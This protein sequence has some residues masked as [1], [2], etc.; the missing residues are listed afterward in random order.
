MVFLLASV[1]N[2]I[3][4]GPV[5]K[6]YMVLA[7]EFK[8][9]DAIITF[10]WDTLL[11]RALFTS[12]IWSPRNGYYIKPEAIYDDQWHDPNTI[13]EVING[14]LYLKVHG[15]TNWLAPY[16]S[17]NLTTGEKHSMSNYA[18]DKLFLFFKATKPYVTYEDR[19][20]GSYEP[21][22]YCYYPPNLPI[23]RDN[24]ENGH[25][26]IRIVSACDLPE[27]G[28]TVVGGKEVYSIPMIV[29]PVRNKQY[30][31]YGIIFISLW[32]KSREVLS[33]CKQLF[34]I[35]YSFPKT[36]IETK[37]VFSE[38]LYLTFRTPDL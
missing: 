15:S 6:P 5:S 32:E 19:Y 21:F 3:Q 16:H 25:T 20:W 31:R 37:K 8:N 14:P 35:G 27:H 9:D 24:I 34:I 4:N 11:D 30:E 12:G 36:D 10:N 38:C 23:D 1:F 7:S 28:R 13:N 29:P 18:I 22:S 33:Q 17:I 26:A 2:E